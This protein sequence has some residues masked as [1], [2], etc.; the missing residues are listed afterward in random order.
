[1]SDGLSSGQ[2]EGVGA[3]EGEGRGGKDWLGAHLRRAGE[4]GTHICSK[5]RGCPERV[6]MRTWETPARMKSPPS[7][8]EDMKEDCLYFVSKASAQSSPRYTQFCRQP[9]FV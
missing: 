8:E 4:G 6:Q 5:A 2:G 9:N 1:M 3:A 7:W